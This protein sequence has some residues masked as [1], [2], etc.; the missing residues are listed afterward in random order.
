MAK[1]PP[2]HPHDALIRRTFGVPEHAAGELKAVL[3]PAVCA[4]VRWETLTLSSTSVVDPELRDRHLTP[5]YHPQ[6]GEPIVIATHQQNGM[7]R[8]MLCKRT[9]AVVEPSVHERGV[10]AVAP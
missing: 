5:P 2:S 6:G 7:V 8:G 3:P 4:S 10:N 9:T 1:D